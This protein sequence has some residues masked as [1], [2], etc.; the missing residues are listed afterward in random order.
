M[1]ILHT[2]LADLL[3]SFLGRPIL[4]FLE[5]VL[6]VAALHVDAGSAPAQQ[7]LRRPPHFV[8]GQAA[9]VRAH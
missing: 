7:V 5:H 2:I 3:Y 1:T 8:P 9:Q 4:V 6:E